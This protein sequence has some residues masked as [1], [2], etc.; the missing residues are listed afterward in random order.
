MLGIMFADKLCWFD[1]NSERSCKEAIKQSLKGNESS[2]RILLNCIALTWSFVLV[3]VTLCAL[4]LSTFESSSSWLVLNDYNSAAQNIEIDPHWCQASEQ[5]VIHWKLSAI[6]NYL[7][8]LCGGWLD[9][10]TNFNSGLSR[11]SVYPAFGVWFERSMSRI[12]WR[13]NLQLAHVCV[14]CM[15]ECNVCCF[16]F[17]RHT[18]MGL[19]WL[20]SSVICVL[21]VNTH[22]DRWDGWMAEVQTHHLHSSGCSARFASASLIFYCCLSVSLARS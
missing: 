12:W 2:D 20:N 11:K 9:L 17:L 16:V 4:H 18:W 7:F 8:R 10:T 22:E 15:Y 3:R 6:Y 5:R 13:E 19:D 21:I 14:W 1:F